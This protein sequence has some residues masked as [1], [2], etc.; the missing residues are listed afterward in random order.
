MK[1]LIVFA[2]AAV[3]ASPA[4]ASKARIT[5][6]GNSRQL[7]DVQYVFDRPYLLNETAEQLTM[8]WGNT[9]G[10]TPKA[11]AGIF[12]KIGEGMF[13]L[14]LGRQGLLTTVT[15]VPLAQQNP[16]NLLY[17]SKAGDIAWGLN[18]GYSNGKDDATDLKSN[19][20]DLTVG[21]ATGA[22]EVE[23]GMS[24]GAKAENATESAEV[25][26]DMNLG[27]GYDLN[28]TQHAYFTYNTHKW[29]EDVGAGDSSE[30]KTTMEL[31]YINTL[32][33]TDDANFFYGVAYNTSKIKDGVETMALPVW[34]GV[35][36]T[37]TSWMTLRA[38][39]KQ[40]VLINEEKAA[41]GDKSDLDSIDFNAG[42]G[43][44][45]G[46]GMLDATF[47]TA[48]AGHVSFSDG[49]TDDFLA[50]VSYTYMW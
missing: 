20:M 10:N 19:S 15:D 1:K 46:K 26:S 50:N 30:E 45:L 9:S 22:W 31:G 47:G 4:F 48:K 18:F 7:N 3:M 23:L 6:L 16:I 2:A 33:K 14:Y 35:E 29:E 17:G 49:G 25:K 27:V 34:M 28:E 40:S 41:N 8:E 42:A 11:E 13:G 38:S 5:A 39:V 43:I 24:L 44:K 36:A 12:T 21:A 37:A 32:V